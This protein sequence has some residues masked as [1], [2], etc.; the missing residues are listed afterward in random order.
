MKGERGIVERG[1]TEKDGRD[2][3]DQA[4]IERRQEEKIERKRKMYERGEEN[5]R[6]G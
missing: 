3:I 5:E 2:K 1:Q 4:E 6:G